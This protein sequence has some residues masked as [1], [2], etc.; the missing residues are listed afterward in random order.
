MKLEQHAAELPCGFERCE[1][2]A[3]LGECAFARVR[4]LVSRHLLRGLRVE[5]EAGRR[6]LRPPL[7]GLGRR[8]PVERRVDLNRVETLCVVAKSRLGRPHVARV[9]VLDQSFVG[10]ATRA[11]TYDRHAPTIEALRALTPAAR[12]ECGRVYARPLSLLLFL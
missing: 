8:Q 6:S 4:F 12:L 5:D 3:K 10:P 11:E 1:R 9:P 2:P 7:R